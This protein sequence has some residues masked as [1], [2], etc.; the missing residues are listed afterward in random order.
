MYMAI[1]PRPRR[2]PAFA[3]PIPVIFD[4]ASLVLPRNLIKKGSEVPGAVHRGYTS[5]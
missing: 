3:L 5:V 2:S 4:F 1:G